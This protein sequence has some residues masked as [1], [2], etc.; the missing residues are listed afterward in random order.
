MAS[1]TKSEVE[2]PPPDKM[3]IARWDVLIRWDYALV[4]FTKGCKW[5]VHDADP[6]HIYY[7]DSPPD[8]WTGVDLSDG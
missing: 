7:A 2:T 4:T 8:S 1:W 3:V 6:N 5:Q